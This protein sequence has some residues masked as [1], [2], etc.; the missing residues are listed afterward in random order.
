MKTT[1]YKIDSMKNYLLLLLL[2]TSITQ[3]QIINFP[4]PVFKAKLLAADISNN[5]A[6]D[7]FG[8]TKID[9]NNNG[10]IEVS[11]AATIY[12]LNIADS[13]ITD[14]TGI[15]DF[16]SMQTL[17]CQNNQITS[18]DASNLSSLIVLICSNNQLT[19]LNV[20]SMFNLEMLECSTNQ[21]TTMNLNG[22]G[23]SSL[24]GLSCSNNQ[25]VSINVSGISTLENLS[26]SDNQLTTLSVS[27]LANLKSINC[28]NN[29]LTTLSV[30]SL[31][32]MEILWCYNNQLTSLN[33]TGAMSSFYEL[34]CSSNQLTSLNIP[35]LVNLSIL[36]CGNNLLT[37][38]NTT[39]LLN[40][41]TYDCDYNQMT[42]LN[43]TGLPMLEYLSCTYNQLT[44]LNVTNLA[45][46]KGLGCNNNLLT[47][48][49]FTGL[50]SLTGLN[51]SY[52]ALPTADLSVIPNLK[53]VLAA[54]NQLTSLNVNGLVN[55]EQILC[56]NNLLTSLNVSGLTSLKVLWCDENQLTALDLSGLVNLEQLTCS[57]NQIPSLNFSGL[58]AL[59]Y[60]YCSFNPIPVLNVS[61]LTNLQALFC[62]D[63]L[64]TALDV[65]GLTNLTNLQCANNAIPALN[66]SGLIN[67]QYLFCRNNQIPSLDLTGFVNLK[68]LDCADNQLTTLDTS[69]CINLTL[70][71][72]C[73]NNNLST[74]FVKNGINENVAFFGNPNLQF[75]CAD[76]MEIANI[77]TNIELNSPDAVVSSYCSFTP[78]G[79]YNSVTGTAH[80]DMNANGCDASDIRANNVRFDMSDGTIASGT[81]LNNTGIYTLYADI[82]NYTL[83][84]HLENPSIFNITPTTTTHNFPA[85]NS[86]VINQDFCLTANGVHNDAEIVLFPTDVAR[87]GFDSPYL[88]FIKNKGNQ[89]L[90]GSVNLVFDDARTDFVSALPNADTVAPNSLTWNYTDLL[91]FETRTIALTL[92]I[93]SPLETP[94]VNSN[95]ILP[96]TATINPIVGDDLPEDNVFNLNQIVVNSFDPNDINCLEGEIV[97]P[98]EIGKYLHYVA[99]FENTGNY[100]AEN[101]VVKIAIDPTKYDVN[102]LQLLHTSQLA[103]TKITGNVV[104][105]IFRNINLAPA[106][107]D[108]PVGGHGTI[109]FKLKSKSTLVSG[110]EVSNKADI[111]F[112]YNAPIT[113]NDARTTFA[114]LSNPGFIKDT[115]VVLHPN[116]TKGNLKIDADHMIKV[117]ELYDIQ[118]RILQTSIENTTTAKL[119]I[120]NKA[121][122]IYFVK[123]TTE[124][125]TN[126]EKVIKE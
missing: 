29:L 34:N 9:T 22:Q 126:I 41:K 63:T 121:N 119:D 90:S 52:N 95:D 36:R 88:L 116:P 33:L 98:S 38:V 28:G 66:V 81:F 31:S 43:V 21:L 68:Q 97:P 49:D 104:E 122:G 93:N 35:T 102:T 71:T 2:F 15:A 54:N 44:S 20:T 94:A 82:G 19:S 12:S 92:N 26:C 105:F 96:F 101:V 100:Q 24:R 16:T 125:G 110:D 10:E 45:N 114:L 39:N 30:A 56:M 1:L 117:I 58:N 109:M 89:P 47:A 84:A 17:F 64:L 113:T 124:R 91:P 99:R 86:T 112:D 111:F 118:G 72:S 8:A 60:I 108:P 53:D 18:L 23:L 46:L 42:T 120:A 37:S 61:G 6:T 75:V 4:D 7:F 78:G 83:N 51:F 27:G 107:G 62:S 5:I 55:L 80:Y 77:Q 50:T 106:A 67:L 59:I 32:N 123:I 14:L 25:L 65:S 85:L 103:D 87:P 57:K 48:I 3:A 69:D 79:N 76:E 74:L 13:G 70:G 11:E 73:Q 40:L 115:S